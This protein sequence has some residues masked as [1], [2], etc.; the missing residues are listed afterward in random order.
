MTNCQPLS[1]N[2]TDLLDARDRVRQE[3]L[4]ISAGLR[5]DIVHRREHSRAVRQ[6]AMAHLRTLLTQLL[7][8]NE[9]I[10]MFEH[11]R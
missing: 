4:N 1:V 3:V 11:G 9:Q 8:L 10:H 6:A 2:I 7:A 5:D